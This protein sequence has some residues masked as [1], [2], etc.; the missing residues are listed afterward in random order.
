MNRHSFYG[1]TAAM[2]QG[3]LCRAARERPIHP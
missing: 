2:R 3:I 1:H